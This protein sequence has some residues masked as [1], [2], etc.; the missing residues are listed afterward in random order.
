MRFKVFWIT[1]VVPNT[2]PQFTAPFFRKTSTVKKAVAVKQT[3]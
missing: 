1:V 3:D 2:N